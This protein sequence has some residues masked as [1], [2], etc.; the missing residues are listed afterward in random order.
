[1]ERAQAGVV[2]R[3]GLAQ[4]QV[5]AHDADDVHLLLDELGEV[6]GHLP[7][8][9]VPGSRFEVL[10]TLCRVRKYECS[11]S[12]GWGHPQLGIG[13]RGLQN[14]PPKDANYSDSSVRKPTTRISTRGSI[15]SVRALE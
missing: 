4:L 8:F 14:C 13:D 2:L 3:A 6:V 10:A 5:L 12:Q 9:E 15:F 7:G 11:G 1:V